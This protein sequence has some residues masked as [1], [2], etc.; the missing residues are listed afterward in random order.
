MYLRVAVLSLVARRA[1]IGRYQSRSD[2]WP[3]FEVVSRRVVRCPRSVRLDC[4]S[5]HTAL[6]CKLHPT[7]RYL[8]AADPSGGKAVH[9]STKMAALRGSQTAHQD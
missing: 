5:R 8:M 7:Y 2:Y 4:V 1:V 3:D 9:I 6:P